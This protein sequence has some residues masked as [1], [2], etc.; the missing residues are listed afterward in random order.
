MKKSILLGIA[1]LAISAT[2]TFG[3][4]GIILDNYS[5][6]G[7]IIVYGPGGL[8]PVGAGLN[9]AWTAGFYF[10]QGDV[11]SSIAA[12]PTG[13]ADPSTLGGGL[14]LAGG[15]GSTAGFA[16]AQV[17]SL[18]GYFL[19][20]A[21]FVINDNPGDTITLMVVAYTGSTYATALNRG[22]SDAFIMT[23]S[24]IT[25]PVPHRVGDYMP[26]FSVPVP[27][28]ATLALG[29]LGLAGLLLFRRKQA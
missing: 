15:L 25:S 1:A 5:S 8:G 11:R 7:P 26:G 29:G 4:S 14:T 3:Q 28:P 12:D 18:P 23:T 9:S 6:Y 27:E 20:N 17:G 22:H 10:A 16:N 2:S 13:F 21:T 19:A 24:D